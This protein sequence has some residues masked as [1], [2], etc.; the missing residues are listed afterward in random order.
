M[1]P[2]DQRKYQN[3]FLGESGLT[4]AKY[5]CYSV[6][7]SIIYDIPV[8][9]LIALFNAKG[10]YSKEGYII[11]PKE[12]EALHLES[13]DV[14]ASD[15]K[16]ICMAEVDFNP[17]PDKDQHFVVWLGD[18]NIIDPWGGVK[19]KNQY[20]VYSWRVYKPLKNE[21]MN[22][23][24][25]K[26][27]SKLVG[28]D[29]GDNLNDGEQEDAAKRIAKVIEEQGDLAS[30]YASISSQK[31]ALEDENAGLRSDVSSLSGQLS[32]TKKDLVMVSDEASELR[33][34][35]SELKDSQTVGIEEY[36]LVQ[37]AGAFFRKLINSK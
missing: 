3:L 15:P 9:E 35:N 11:H 31:D 4:V 13:Y 6:C 5:G 37:I 1:T 25:V 20:K 33:K 34:Q 23:D 19:K 27:V 8:E 2:Y 7:F 21:T 32:A 26:S 28:K 36:S 16:S 10:V 14:V 17:D 24:F 22:K 29:Y 30:E 18:G 12:V